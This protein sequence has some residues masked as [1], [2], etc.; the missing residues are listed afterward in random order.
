MTRSLRPSAQPVAQRQRVLIIGPSNIGDAILAGDVVDAVA[1]RYPHA[2]LT[3][4]VGERAKPLFVDDPRIHT[5]VETEQFDSPLGRLKLALTLWRYHPHIVVDLRHTLY[6]LLLKPFAGWRY[7]RQPPKGLPHMRDRHLWKLQAQVPGFRLPRSPR[8]RAKAGEGIPFRCTARDAAHAEGMWNRWRLDGRRV[9]MICPG[10]RSHIKRWTTAG[11]ASVADRLIADARA[12][13]IF[14]GE[15][16]E[17]PIIDEILG[18]MRHRAHS[19]AGLTTIRQLGLLMQ[20]THLVITNDS[21]ALHLAS[22]LQVPTVAI[23]GPTDAAKYGPT[24]AQHRTIRR[25]LFCAPCEQALCRFSHECM[26]FI[27]PNEVFDAAT[28]LL[29]SSPSTRRSTSRR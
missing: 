27:G 16:S 3:L 28:Q 6:P 14:S 5:L 20:R 24:T 18:L 25:R 11:F 17:Q 21:A 9:V 23:F 2:H 22:S 12:E 10:A 29:T 19:T 8:K 13:V 26:R 15:L 4:V 1:T 7:V